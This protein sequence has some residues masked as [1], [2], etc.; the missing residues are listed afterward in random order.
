MI[1]LLNSFN[2]FSHSI[3]KSLVPSFTG[4]LR[5]KAGRPLVNHVLKMW[6]L[7]KGSIT[8]SSVKV[9]V[10]F[11]RFLFKLNK[12][13]GIAYV[14]KYLKSCTSLLMQS[15]SG[16]PHGSSQELGLA[17]S[18]TN[19]GLPRIIPAVHRVHIKAGNLYYIRLWLTLFSLYRVL[20]FVGPLKIGTIITPS[21][22]IIDF[23]ELREA[24]ESFKASRFFSVDFKPLEPRPFWIA[25]S[26]PNSTKMIKNKD[27]QHI[28]PPTYSTSIFAIVNSLLAWSNNPTLRK[29]YM[30]LGDALGFQSSLMMGISFSRFTKRYYPNPIWFSSEQALSQ[31]TSKDIL[32]K[33]AF[34]VEPAGKIRVF[35]MVDCWTQWLLKPL[36]KSLFNFLHSLKSDAT[37]NQSETLFRFVKSLEERNIRK[38]YSFDLTAATDRIPVSAQAVILDTLFH[39]DLGATWASL[40]VDRWYDLPF[41]AWDP[42]AVSVKRLGIDPTSPYVR[43]KEVE[44]EGHKVLVVDAVRYATGQPMGA[45]SSWA[46]LAVTHHTMVR[47]AALRSGLINFSDY[48]VLGDDLVIAHPE[49]ARHYLLLAKEW[50]IGINLSKS[51]LSRN[52]S[53][54]FAKRFVYKYKDV[55]GLSFK[56]M[57]VS[58]HDIRGLIQLFQRIS[59]FRSIRISELLSFLGH[60]YRALSRINGKYNKMGKG[61]RRALLLVSYPGLLFSQFK[62]HYQWL[63]SV[64]FN[65]ATFLS[66]DSKIIKFLK[67]LGSKV[68]DSIKQSDLP[69]NPEEFKTMFSKLYGYDGP[70]KAKFPWESGR[71]SFTSLIEALEAPLMPMYYDIL[72][73]WDS[74]MVEVKDTFD[75]EDE[76]LSVDDLWGM[77]ETLEDI[78]SGANAASDYRPI[79]DIQTLGSCTLLRRVEKIRELYSKLSGET[80][81]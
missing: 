44:W 48:L 7:V 15:L 61:M 55:S 62:S 66:D 67:D 23:K 24:V 31:S 80:H 63:S 35:A 76:D 74:T 25:S 10:Y 41:P 57:M 18:R 19:R 40:L 4:M 43:T 51:V 68:S 36:H 59:G 75:M 77:L 22:A 33:L 14:A 37:F 47:I 69:R 70:R 65:R 1:K 27:T 5:V 3:I 8:N 78:S 39:R 20:D 58:Y 72:E 56:E 29:T 53:L 11:V 26:S 42:M 60:G 54:E 50:D 17:V 21:K 71:Y 81:K 49:V 34:K 9:T 46:M 16:E 32:G 64:A 38:V 12:T 52:G 2:N 45:L 28:T 79:K 30:L 13:N 73:S 6:L